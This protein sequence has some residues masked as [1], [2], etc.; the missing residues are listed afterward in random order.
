MNLPVFREPRRE[1]PGPGA[2]A[3]FLLCLGYCRL[4]LTQKQEPGPT[5]EDI[6]IMDIDYKR[7]DAPEYTL[8]QDEELEI[9]EILNAIS[10]SLRSGVLVI[11]DSYNFQAEKL[12]DVVWAASDDE[13]INHAGTVCPPNFIANILS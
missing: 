8:R 9:R 3:R 7:W 4:M 12:R 1:S 5:A 11:G 6:D 10:L 13:P 2:L